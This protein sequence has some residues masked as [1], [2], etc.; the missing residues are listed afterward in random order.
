MGLFTQLYA[1][2]GKKLV[3]ILLPFNIVSIYWVYDLGEIVRSRVNVS[4]EDGRVVRH[5][6]LNCKY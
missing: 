5:C 6:C 2:E 4:N 3:S 1:M